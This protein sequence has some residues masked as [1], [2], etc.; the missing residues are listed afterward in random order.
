M[1]K[2]R[3][4]SRRQVREVTGPAHRTPQAREG[5]L[6][7]MGPGEDFGLRSNLPF[8]LVWLLAE[9]TY[10]SGGVGWKKED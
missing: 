7:E 9:F 3:S 1:S 10:A 5:L 2:E 4:S 8:E 6:P